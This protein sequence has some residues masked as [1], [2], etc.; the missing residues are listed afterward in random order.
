MGLKTPGTFCWADLMPVDQARAIAFYGDL[1]SWVAGDPVPENG[2][3]SSQF[4][5][6]LDFSTRVAGIAGALPGAPPRWL[7][8]LATDDVEATAV[9]V[10]AAG[11]K[12]VFAPHVV[13]GQRSL[14][15]FADPTGAAFG[16]WQADGHEGFG[17]FA[18]PGAFCWA[19]VYTREARAAAEFYADVF[20]LELDVLSETDDFTYLLLRIA[21]QDDPVFGVMQMGDAYPEHL[22]AS[23][24]AYLTTADTDASAKEVVRLGGK[25]IRQPW[26][27]PFGHMALVED[28]EG[29]QFYLS[30]PQRR[31]GQG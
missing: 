28:T 16:V 15:I 24:A 31:N 18:V 9:H 1:L 27:S 17:P 13:P 11:G 22:G 3:Y 26:D 20:D 25:V 4:L 5:G 7:T 21:G 19:E 2:G 14:A 30:N 23:W 8:Y 12:V 29:A 6:E 10:A